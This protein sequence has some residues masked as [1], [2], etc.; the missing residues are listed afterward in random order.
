MTLLLEHYADALTRYLGSKFPEMRRRGDIDD[1]V[2]EV[3]LALM[4]QGHVLQRADPAHGG[5]FRHFLMRVAYN[6]ARNARRRL[7]RHHWSLLA[8]EAVAECVNDDTEV[9]H[10]TEMD[11][12]WAESILHQ[13]WTELRAWAAQGH[14]E[15]DGV[16]LLERNLLNNQALRNAAGE[17]GLSLGTAHRRIAKARTLLRQAVIEHL[18][19]TGELIEGNEDEA[20]DLLM[21]A[22]QI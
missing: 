21:K 5:R 7:D 9:L 6:A 22:L 15:A 16:E 10:E 17:M 18:R 19:F 14:I 13:A 20:F 4:R 11:R 2:Q 8:D 12:A 1:L 3:L